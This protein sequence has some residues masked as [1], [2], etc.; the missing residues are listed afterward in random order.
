MDPN[1]DTLPFIWL[2]V[3]AAQVDIRSLKYALTKEGRC[4]EFKLPIDIPPRNYYLFA[5]VEAGESDANP[6][7]GR[8]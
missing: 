8:G 7:L 6:K 4:F 3:I 1:P 5:K 2:T